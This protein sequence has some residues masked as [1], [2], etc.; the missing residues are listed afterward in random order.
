MR[1][2]RVDPMPGDVLSKKYRG[3]YFESRGYNERTVDEVGGGRVI[4]VGDNVCAPEIT[5]KSWR[6]WATTAKVVHVAEGAK[7]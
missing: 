1:D 3:R 5:L 7:P 6:K 2:P 4:Y